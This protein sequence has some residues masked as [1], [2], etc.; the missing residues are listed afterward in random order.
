MTFKANS[1]A[2]RQFAAAL[3]ATYGDVADAKD[4]VK[5]H[6]DF[7]FHQTG[8]IGVLS[9]SHT[10]FMDELEKM[11]EITLLKYDSERTAFLA[12]GLMS[13]HHDVAPLRDQACA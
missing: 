10:A 4:Y 9:G 1:H 3:Q 8:L 13:H 5:V 7:S 11:L 2:I 12:D 6:G